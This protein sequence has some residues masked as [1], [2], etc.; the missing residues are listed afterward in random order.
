MSLK[1]FSLLLKQ[2]LVKLSFILPETTPPLII[3]INF[4]YRYNFANFI[5]LLQVSVN[6]SARKDEKEIT[7]I[8]SGMDS[9]SSSLDLL[10]RATTILPAIGLR[11]LFK[12][13]A[14]RLVTICSQTTSLSITTALFG[15]NPSGVNAQLAVITGSVGSK[16][17]LR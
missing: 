13:C 17:T 12:Y 3:P 14:I 15:I 1:R 8:H 6:V 11:F 5:S 16:V 10:P 2:K 7:S 4:P 9:K